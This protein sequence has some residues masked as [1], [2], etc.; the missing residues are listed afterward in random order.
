M[1]SI[2][3]KK[4][5]QKKR[6][7][8]KREARKIKINRTNRTFANVH[9]QKLLSEFVACLKINKGEIWGLEIELKNYIIV[10]IFNGIIINNIY[11]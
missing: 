10:D 6:E 11:N 1:L 3:F 2:F 9:E 7:N 4:P 5:K 8:A